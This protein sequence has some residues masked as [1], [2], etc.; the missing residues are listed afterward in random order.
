ML[1]GLRTAVIVA[2]AFAAGY[3]VREGVQQQREFF[4]PQAAVAECQPRSLPCGDLHGLKY[5]FQE[6]AVQPPLDEQHVLQPSS[7]TNR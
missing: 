2:M 6:V 3:A 4:R 1:E 5:L 7:T